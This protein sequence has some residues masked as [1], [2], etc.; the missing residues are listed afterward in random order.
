MTDLAE[1]IRETISKADMLDIIECVDGLNDIRQ[2]GLCHGPCGCKDRLERV[3][4]KLRG[5]VQ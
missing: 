1:V 5:E 3:Q 2:A 4:A